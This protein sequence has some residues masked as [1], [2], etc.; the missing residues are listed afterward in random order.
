MKAIVYIII[1]GFI[2]LIGIFSKK[3]AAK[4]A[5][6]LFSTPMKGFI[7]KDQVEF[8]DTAYKEEFNYNTH[9]IITYRWP[10]KGKTI[11]LV[12]GWESNSARW[13]N[14]ILRL[15]KL[16]YNIIALDAPAHGNSSGKRFT[17]LLYAE[18]INVITRRFKPNIIIGHSAGAMACTFALDKYKHTEIGKMVLISSPSEFKDILTRYTKMLK[19]SKRVT[20]GI[21]ELI[22]KRFNKHPKEFS[23]ANSVKNLSIECLIFHDEKDNIIPYNDA[24][25]IKSSLNNSKL[26]STTGLGHSLNDETV[27]Q[28]IEDFIAQ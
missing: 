23:T 14:L 26:I 8:L 6:N 9:T 12:H 1:G 22:I 21:E 25:K 27:Y 4:L 19:F 2:N 15:N 20:Q 17:A 3:I 5:L 13:K 24:L 18:F 28:Q 11:L 10:G 7:R 16:D